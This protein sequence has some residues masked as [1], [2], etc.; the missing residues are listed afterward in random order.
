MPISPSPFYDRD[1]ERA[2]LTEALTSARSELVILSGRRGVGKS[3]LL[4]CVLRGAGVPFIFYRATRRTLPLQLAA[5]TEAVREAY[6]AAFIGQPFASTPVFL[7]FLA[8]Q[9]GEAQATGAVVVAVLDELPY[10][11][12]VDPGLLTIL[13]HWWDTNKRRPNLKLFLAGSY[14]AFMERQVLDQ[15]APLYNRRTGAIRLEPMDY[16]EAALF[17][18][19]YTPEERMLAFSVLGG[20]PSYLEQFDPAKD[21]EANVKATVLR[22]NTYLSE[23]PDWLLL[24]DLRR[25]VIHGSI[26]R[27]VAGGQRKPSDI[28]RAI[29]KKAAQ[30]IAPQ[31]ATLQDLGLLVREVP[32]TERTQARSRN[33]LYFVAD[34]Y[35]AFWYRYVDPA[36]SLVMRGLGERIWER[37]IAPTLAEYVSRPPFERACR[38]YLW[39]SLVAG[40]LPGGLEFTEVGGW[41]GGGD[42]EIDVVAVK[43]NGHVVLVGSCKWTAA[44]MDVREYAAL[45]RDLTLAGLDVGGADAEPWFALFSRSGFTPRLREIAAAQDP[46]R[47]LLVDLPSLYSV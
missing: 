37:S 21:V 15:N 2:V 5:L 12:D 29:G 7:D 27:A 35:L 36:R 20:M 22:Q 17:F 31:L 40:T 1:R 44:P 30:D 23:E 19:S 42:R 9:A 14:V 45:Q 28:A 41:W 10:L 25:D 32:I 16:A 34:H 11:A 33:S 39:R 13:Q 26:L 4:D 18:S 24:E 43:E 8:H 47:L 38:Q 6:P 46:P 3:A